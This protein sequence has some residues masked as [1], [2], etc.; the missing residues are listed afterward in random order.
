MPDRVA[1]I[2][3]HEPVSQLI[4]SRLAAIAR[5]FL[6][7]HPSALF[8]PDSESM[9][10]ELAEFPWKLFGS[11]S[12]K[13]ILH[14][15]SLTQRPIML[16]APPVG[17]LSH[18]VETSLTHK[19]ESHFSKR[20]S[21]SLPFQRNLLIRVDSQGGSME[22][23]TKKNVLPCPFENDDHELQSLI[24]NLKEQPGTPF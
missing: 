14:P 24:G 8:E 3:G 6:V 1:S 5:F 7:R 9:S 18:S 21:G 20:E 12:K 23:K 4:R 2:E 17:D 10:S 15:G 19:R 22:H 13:L 16:C 11:N